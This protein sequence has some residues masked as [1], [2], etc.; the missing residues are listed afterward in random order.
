[1]FRKF[2][3]SSLPLFTAATAMAQSTDRPNII[4]FLADDMGRQDISI[5][6]FTLDKWSLSHARSSN[7][8]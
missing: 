5:V 8:A 3:R 2:F 6:H 1:M 4:F 7:D